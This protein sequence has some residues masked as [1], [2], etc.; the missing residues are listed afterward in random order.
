MVTMMI[1][2]KWRRLWISPAKCNE[3]HKLELPWFGATMCSFRTHRVSEKKVALN[4][5]PHEDQIKEAIF[6]ETLFKA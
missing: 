1:F 2:L 3:L 5:L 6:E 4:H